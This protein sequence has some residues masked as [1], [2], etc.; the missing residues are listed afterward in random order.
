[1]VVTGKVAMLI[2]ILV[3]VIVTTIVIEV[4]DTSKRNKNNLIALPQNCH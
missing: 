2:A 3:I 4:I 1:M